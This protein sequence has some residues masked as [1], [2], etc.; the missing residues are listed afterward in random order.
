MTVALAPPGGPAV[1]KTPVVKLPQFLAGQYIVF[2]GSLVGGTKS[3][4]YSF[5]V[6]AGD[7]APT[8][9]DG[10]A[11]YNIVARAQQVGMTVLAGYNPVSLTVPIRFDCFQA[12]WVDSQTGKVNQ[13]AAQLE[14]DIQILDWM[15][16][17]GKLFAQDGGVGA[18]GIGDS[19]LVTVYSTDSQGYQT[20]LI[21]PTVQ[22]LQMVVSAIAWDAS[23]IRN[24]AGYRTR[25]DCTVTLL[26]W[27][28]DRFSASAD[29]SSARAKATGAV[30]GE[31]KTVTTTGSLNTIRKIA[32]RVAN[33][34]NSAW[35]I[36]QA[37]KGDTRV[38]T[39]VDKRL[40]TGTRIKVPTAVIKGLAS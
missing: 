25:Q 12:D 6:L 30:A 31:Y 27:V 10:Y 21:P 13:T 23:P 17:R 19:P 14:R 15:G 28:Q 7:G 22:G 18:P 9:T 1:A 11:N 5:A 2:A 20:P 8:I 24:T 38:G 34:P 16:G 36:L 35:T 32:G 4:A 37:N 33:N 39:S 3:A 40:P 29:S 26:E